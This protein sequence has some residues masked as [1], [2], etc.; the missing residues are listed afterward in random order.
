MFIIFVFYLLDVTLYIKSNDLTAKTTM[1][2]LSM[3]MNY[4]VSPKVSHQYDGVIKAR[5]SSLGSDTFT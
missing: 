1:V 5:Q 4:P 2:I 3:L